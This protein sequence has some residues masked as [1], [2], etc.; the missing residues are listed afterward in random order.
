MKELVEV[1]FRLAKLLGYRNYAAYSLETEMIA[2]PENA[3]N[4]I[5]ELQVGTAKKLQEEKAELQDALGIT[6]PLKQWQVYY[7]KNLVAKK[8]LGGFERSTASQ[9]FRVTAVIRGL[10]HQ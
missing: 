7:A 4:L 1:R 10:L 3:Y 6:E 5:Q 9:F 2:S 8:K